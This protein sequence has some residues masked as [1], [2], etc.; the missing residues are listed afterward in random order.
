MKQFGIDISELKKI[1]LDEAKSI[2]KN[3]TYNTRD[4]I[5]KEYLGLR[6]STF[7]VMN[8]ELKE[9]KLAEIITEI[10]EGRFEVKPEMLGLKKKNF[11]K[12]FFESRKNKN[13][14]DTPKPDHTEG[15]GLKHN[16]TTSEKKFI[17]PVE[18]S[19]QQPLIPTSS[20]KSEIQTPSKDPNR[21]DIE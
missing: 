16:E 5:I 19:S 20:K 1:T 3:Y 6:E 14:L 9:K 21:E 8:E 7:I 15:L 18:I 10:K 2:V 17:P 11:L 12:R 13:I 4:K